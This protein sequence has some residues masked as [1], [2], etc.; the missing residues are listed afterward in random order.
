M[1]RSFIGIGQCGSAI[2][3]AI[4]EEKNMF[5]IAEP[6]VINSDVNDLKKLKNIG[7]Q[8]WLGISKEK[9]F[10]EGKTTGFGEHVTGGFGNY[11][12]NA[13]KIIKPN[14]EKLKEVL[15][16]RIEKTT[17]KSKN[18]NKPGIPFALLCVGTGG[19]TGSGTAPFV[20]RAIKELYNIP[21]IVIAVIPASGEGKEGMHL[22]WNSWRCIKKLSEHVNSFILVDNEKL[23]HKRSIESFFPKYNKYIARCLTDLIAG[24][25]IEKIDLSKLNFGRELKDI[26]FMDMVSTTSFQSNGKN[27]PGFAVI[28]R[29]SR[30]MRTLFYY[31]PII[32]KLPKGYK[33]IEPKEML[34]EAIESLSME[35]E[36][37]ELAN[38]RKNLVNL[39][40]PNYYLQKEEYLDTSNI[41]KYMEQYSREGWRILGISRTK[42]DL[43]S[44]TV[45]FTFL[46]DELNRLLEIEETAR[47]YETEKGMATYQEL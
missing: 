17:P 16:N 2:L 11:P 6:I 30:Q 7:N 40:V 25:M 15:K 35:I 1:A 10:I 41:K 23:S 26:D 5:Q 34:D 14:Y 29:A 28:G 44:L 33:S 8:Y 36:K 20:A 24:L 12:E 4:F 42:R 38:A 46:P 19:G 43:V 13:E 32:S 27:N 22:S 9:G 31:M 21:I 39:R 3:D 18:E 47:K 45:L 37:S